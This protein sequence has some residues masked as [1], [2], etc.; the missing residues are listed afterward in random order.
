MA[1]WARATRLCA[2]ARE[3]LQRSAGPLVKAAVER[4]E[5]FMRWSKDRA[6]SLGKAGGVEPALRN[7]LAFAVALIGLMVVSCGVWAATTP[8]GR[9]VIASGIVVVDSNIKKVQHPTGG[10]VAQIP[11]KNGDQ[12]KAGDTVLKLDDTQARANLGIVASQLVQLI[13]RKARLEA[14]RDL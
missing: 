13:G 4:S 14:E 2:E 7:R 12:V 6:R 8:I 3:R 11:V 5:A 9:A 10:I 1:D